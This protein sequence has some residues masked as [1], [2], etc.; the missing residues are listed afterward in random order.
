ML[1]FI[2]FDDRWF[3][4]GEAM[5]GPLVPYHVGVPCAHITDEELGDHCAAGGTL[6]KVAL[7]PTCTSSLAAAPPF[8]S[9]T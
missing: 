3:D 4:S 2:P 7:S 8:S 1:Q 5:P 6:M 9:S